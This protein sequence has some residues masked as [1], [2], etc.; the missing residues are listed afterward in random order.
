MKAKDYPL[1]LWHFLIHGMGFAAQKFSLKVTH[2][3]EI[4]LFCLPLRYPWKKVLERM[5][6]TVTVD[7][8]GFVTVQE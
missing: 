5:S 6:T 3:L 4:Q 1:I 7:E 2:S 8:N